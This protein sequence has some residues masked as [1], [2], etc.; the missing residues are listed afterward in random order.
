MSPFS[1]LPRQAKIALGLVA[2]L[3]IAIAL[4][5]PVA[6][7]GS[8]GKP[9]AKTLAYKGGDY[10]ARAASSFVQSVAI[11]VGVASGCGTQPA[12][13]NVRSVAGIEVPRAIAVATD[14][15]TL[16]VRKGLCVRASGRALLACLR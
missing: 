15:S 7:R 14:Q 13:V 11:G 9:C 4:T 6:F 1:R 16:Y 12:N 5:A 8:G 2:A 10:T 3:V